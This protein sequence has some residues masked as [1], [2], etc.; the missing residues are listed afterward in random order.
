MWPPRRITAIL[1]GLPAQSYHHIVKK[2]VCNVYEFFD[3]HQASEIIRQFV[4]FYN[5]ERLHSGIG[6]LSPNQ[7]FFK[8]GMKIPPH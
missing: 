6:Y 8:L 3:L 5:G 7:Y 1:T 2:A 4:Y